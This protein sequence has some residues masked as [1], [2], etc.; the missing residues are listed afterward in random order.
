MKQIHDQEKEQFKKLFQQEGIDRFE[1]RF[2]VLDSFLQTEGH[3]TAVELAER[4]ADS[5]HHLEMP[6]LRDTLARMC[7]FGFAHKNSFENGQ[8]VY[9]H[10]HLGQHHDHLI[11][12]K[13]R[14]IVEFKNDRLE[15]LQLQIAE[16]HG[17]HMLQHRMEIYGICVDCVK[18]RSTRMPLTMAKTGERITII[19]FTRGGQV[20]VRL[21]AMGFRIGDKLEVVSNQAT[22]QL[23]VA[24]DFKRYALGRGLAE[25]IVVSTD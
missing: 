14:N 7:R 12:T 23:V 24:L 1:D 6:F 15:S 10:R 22:G 2:L 11:C 4:L 9:E 5:G 21:K 17:F 16:A 20:S 3:I 13:C 25:K 8:T 19:G 18:E